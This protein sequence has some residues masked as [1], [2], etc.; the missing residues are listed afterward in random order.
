MSTFTH[1]EKIFKFD[2]VREYSEEFKQLAG[3]N[4]S[5][6]NTTVE[7]TITLL[8]NGFFNFLA[9]EKGRKR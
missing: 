8:Q 2:L 3:D 6:L 9:E 5:E 1:Q 7:V 4:L